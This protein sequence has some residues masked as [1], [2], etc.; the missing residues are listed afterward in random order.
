MKV[1]EILKGESRMKIECTLPVQSW[2]IIN[3]VTPEHTVAGGPVD[4]E[5]L[6]NLRNFL[7]FGQRKG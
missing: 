7:A 3:C 6:C 1:T 4:A 2:Y 5:F